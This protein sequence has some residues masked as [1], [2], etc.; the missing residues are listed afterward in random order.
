MEYFLGLTFD[1]SSIHYA[2]IDSFR[3]RFDSKF[4]KHENLQLT[5]LPPFIVDFSSLEQER[6]FVEELQELLEGHLFGLTEISQIK[7]HG[8]TFSMAK[9]GSISLTPII[10]PDVIHCQ[11]SLYHF[12]KEYGVKFKNSK[13]A[14]SSILP[15]GRIE[16][17]DLM[18]S[19]IETAKCEF[20]NP[21]I[22][23]ATSLVLFEKTPK[24]WEMKFNLFDFELRDHFSYANHI[25]A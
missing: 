14:S 2:K 3:R 1:P 23:D 22:M 25:Y 9:R 20:D 15:I 4:S 10:S 24:E 12:L 13:S 8:I 6:N 21:F 17:A 7:F 18:N 19:A 5:I 16:Y 11:E